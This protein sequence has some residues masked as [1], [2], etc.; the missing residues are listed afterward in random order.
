MEGGG[1]TI[2]FLDVFL[3]KGKKTKGR[4]G[5]K[6]TRGQTGAQNLPSP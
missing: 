6:R 3:T 1:G 2:R 5:K 4:R